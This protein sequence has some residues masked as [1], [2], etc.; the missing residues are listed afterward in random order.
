MSVGAGQLVVYLPADLAV[1]VDASAGVGAI[2]LPGLGDTGGVGV[3]RSWS[4]TSPASDPG[5]DSLQLDLEVGLGEI[6]VLQNL[7]EVTR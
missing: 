7:T 1:T 5:A 3:D 6:R 2:A 4:S